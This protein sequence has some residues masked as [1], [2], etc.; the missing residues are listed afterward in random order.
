MHT[1]MYM[2][3]WSV[4]LVPMQARAQEGQRVGERQRM[5]GEE[6]EKPQSV[7]TRLV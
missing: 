4:P 7:E 1:Y 6:A 2:P 5:E 3:V